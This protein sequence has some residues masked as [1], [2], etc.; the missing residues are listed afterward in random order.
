MQSRARGSDGLVCTF[1]YMRYYPLQLF[2]TMALDLIVLSFKRYLWGRESPISYK[3]K[4]L[5][6]HIQ[7]RTKNILPFIS[8]HSFQSR[9]T[10]GNVVGGTPIFPL[11]LVLW[12]KARGLDC[13]SP[14]RVCEILFASTF[15]RYGMRPH[16]FA[17][18]KYLIG[19]RRS[20]FI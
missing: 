5:L 18:Q 9:K 7:C 3:L 12:L 11:V 17:L 1:A 2:I 20:H 13:R 14:L 16:D 19:E 4:S 10:L 15:G 8:Q 6:T